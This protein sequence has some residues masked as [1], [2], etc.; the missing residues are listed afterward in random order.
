LIFPE[1]CRA[2]PLLELEIDE[3]PEVVAFVELEM[4]IDSFK[5]LV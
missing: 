3:Q 4:P 1:V 2:F 5:I